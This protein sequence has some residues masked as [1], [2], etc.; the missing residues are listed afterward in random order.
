[1]LTD[2]H[3]APLATLR[4]AVSTIVGV[5]AK[6]QVVWIDARWVVATVTDTQPMRDR[7]IDF[8]PRKTMG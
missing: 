3:L 8:F 6:E 2:G 4:H 1:V 7:P 5:R